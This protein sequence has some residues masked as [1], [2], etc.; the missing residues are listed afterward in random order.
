MQSESFLIEGKKGAQKGMIIEKPLIIE[1]HEGG[2]SDEIKEI[3]GEYY[4]MKGKM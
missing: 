3:Y 2:F 1:N 4:A